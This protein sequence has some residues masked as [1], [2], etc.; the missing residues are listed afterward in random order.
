MTA[1]MKALA[2]LHPEKGIW[3]TEAEVPTVG[4]NDLLIKIKKTAIDTE[5]LPLAIGLCFFIG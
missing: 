5:I 3:M 1:K 4:P 2:K